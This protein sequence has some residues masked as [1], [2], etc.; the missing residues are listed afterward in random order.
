MPMTR[1]RLDLFPCPSCDKP[2]RDCG[3]PVR[4]I[5][6]CHPNTGLRIEYTEGVLTTFCTTCNA[7]AF[8]ILVA[9]T[10]DA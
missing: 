9:K 3:Q 7:M 2:A 10:D 8:Q 1:E 4:P 6:A 5:Q